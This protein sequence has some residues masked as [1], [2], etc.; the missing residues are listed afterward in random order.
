LNEE[1]N[2]MECYSSIKMNEILSF[3]IIWMDLESIM[4]SE[5]SQEPKDMY[6]MIS[7]ICGSYC[8]EVEKKMMV[9]QDW[10]E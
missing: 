5:I 1:N 9:T 2:K 4:L 10:G 8:T 3:V 7:L 6:Y